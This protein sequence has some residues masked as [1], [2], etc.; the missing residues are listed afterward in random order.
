MSTFNADKFYDNRS[1]TS[2]DEKISVKSDLLGYRGDLKVGPRTAPSKRKQ[3]KWKSNLF[4]N[5]FTAN[6]VELFKEKLT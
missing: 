4:N 2:S 1:Q 6:L 3:S 5:V